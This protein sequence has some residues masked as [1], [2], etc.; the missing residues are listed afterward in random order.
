MSFF[1][2]DDDYPAFS[3]F[4]GSI[5][6]CPNVFKQAQAII[7]IQV[8]LVDLFLG[9]DFISES[10]NVL[11]SPEFPYWSYHIMI[12]LILTESSNVIAC[13]FGFISVFTFWICCISA[14]ML[15]L[16]LVK[17]GVRYL[18]EPNQIVLNHVGQLVHTLQKPGINYQQMCT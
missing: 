17:R 8:Q 16:F 6:I 13:I 14:N 15:R 11:K 9:N 18:S 5:S 2:I 10:L 3:A 12:L 7:I 1:L 4:F